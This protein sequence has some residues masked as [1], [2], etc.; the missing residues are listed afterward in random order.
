M[1]RY[2]YGLGKKSPAENAG[3][4]GFLVLEKGLIWQGQLEEMVGVNQGKG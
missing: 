4:N 3:E 2:K 1:G